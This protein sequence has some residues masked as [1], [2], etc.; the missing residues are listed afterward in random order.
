MRGKVRG[1]V[2]PPADV[3]VIPDENSSESSS[4]SSE[5]EVEDEVFVIDSN[6]SEGTVDSS[7]SNDSSVLD[8]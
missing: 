7:D 1:I 6:S 4:V 8:I 2:A 3:L 5:S